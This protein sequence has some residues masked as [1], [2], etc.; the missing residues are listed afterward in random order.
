MPAE[1][2]LMSASPHDQAEGDGAA[3]PSRGAAYFALAMIVAATALNFLNASVFS[4]VT[5]RIKIDLELT[6]EQ[7]GWLIGPGTILIYVLVGIPLARLVDLYS[8]KHVLAYGLMFSSITSALGGLAQSFSALFTTRMLV[9]VGTSAHAP[10]SYSMIADLFPPRLVPRAI[11]FFQIGF[12]AGTTLGLAAGGYLLAI[13]LDWGPVSVFGLEIRAW[14]WAMIIAA[15]PGL[16][17]AIGLLAIR[18]PARKGEV[19]SHAAPTLIEVVKEMWHRRRVYFPLLLGVV[20]CALESLSL[21]NWRSPFMIR[22]YGWSEAEIGAFLA[23][24]LFVTSIAGAFIG[25]RLTEWLSRKYADAHVRA[26]GILFALAAPA[27]ILSTI[28]PNG[29]LALIMMALSAMFALAAGVPQNA[30]FQL[31]T[32]NEMRGQVTAIYVFLFTVTG[33]LGTLGIALITKYVVGDE[34]R[35]W[36]ALAITATLLVPFAILCIA[37]G[38]RPYGAEVQRKRLLDGGIAVAA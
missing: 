22:T 24:I 20:F 31:I 32:P 23:P 16:P 3:W 26:M 12:I 9:G 18:E 7:L 29:K 36:E 17:I 15:A 28:M 21:H 38:L 4:V 25:M 1:P 8:R 10:G 34:S 37:L 11:A 27:A 33:A 14:Q 35:L 6:D 19:E 2:F 13:A 30:A 5:E